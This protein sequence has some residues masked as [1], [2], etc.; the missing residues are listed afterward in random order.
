[1]RRSGWMSLRRERAG[2]EAELDRIRLV[3]A[4]RPW[5]AA[6]LA[7]RL[8]LE[9]AEDVPRLDAAFEK[10]WRDGLTAHAQALSAA[11]ATARHV[12][13][14]GEAPEEVRARIRCWPPPLPLRRWRICGVWRRRRRGICRRWWRGLEASEAAM[15]R[16]RHELGWDAAVVLP[17]APAVRGAKQ[18]LGCPA[19]LGR[20]GGV[21][22]AGRGGS[23]AA[24]GGGVGRAGCAAGACGCE[25]VDGFGRCAARPGRSGAAVGGG[26]GPAAR[27]GSGVG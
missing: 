5:L 25:R 18:R 21:G 23:G 14:Q 11:E 20:E 17:P 13:A 10:S 16:L 24:A 6:R 22:G 19:C 27:G 12:Q 2:V 26:A 15:A 7:A 3:R 9:G 8:L 1:M 4:I